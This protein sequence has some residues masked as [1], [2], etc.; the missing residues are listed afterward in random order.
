LVSQE[1]TLMRE[2][3]RQDDRKR[4]DK[5]LPVLQWNPDTMKE[6]VKEE[7]KK[8]EEKKDGHESD[9]DKKDSKDKRSDDRGVCTTILCYCV[10]S[11]NMVVS[12][13]SQ[14]LLTKYSFML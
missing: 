4:A 13:D 1:K 5:K 3:L 6:E 12:D 10:I 11:L 2:K 8:D 9:K 7:K 14:P